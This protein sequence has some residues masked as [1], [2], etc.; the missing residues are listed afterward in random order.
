MADGFPPKIRSKARIQLSPMLFNIVLEVLAR[1]I[2]QEK[3]IESIQMERKK[4]N[5]LSLLMTKF[6]T[7]KIP[8]KQTKQKI[9]AGDKKHIQQSCVL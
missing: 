4:Q 7:Y 9:P 5:S 3:E 6:N 2:M 8:K 1:A